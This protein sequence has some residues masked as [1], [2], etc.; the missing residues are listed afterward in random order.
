[1]LGIPPSLGFAGRWRLYQTALTMN[2]WLLA[3]FVI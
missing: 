1:M 2:H 3:G